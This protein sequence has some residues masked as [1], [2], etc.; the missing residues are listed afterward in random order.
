VR[1]Y[2]PPF[3]GIHHPSISPDGERILFTGV[4]RGKADLFEFDLAT[5]RITRHTNDPF[6]ESGAV[7]DST[8]RNIYFAS[9]ANRGERRRLD[10]TEREIYRLEPGRGII[11]ITDVKGRCENP[12]PAQNGALYLLCDHTG[13]ANV[14]RID[15]ADALRLSVGADGLTPITSSATGL[16]EPSLGLTDGSGE[17]LLFT[18]IEEGAR[19]IRML[20]S[21]PQKGVLTKSPLPPVSSSI[22]RPTGYE[23]P[24]AGERLVIDS[25]FPDAVSHYNPMLAPEFIFFM[26]SVSSEGYPAA[27]GFAQMSD[28]TGNHRLSVLLSGYQPQGG[29]QKVGNFSLQY[30]YR[31]YRNAFF[32]GAYKQSGTDPVLN[33]FDLSLN[34]LLYNPYFRLLQ[35]DTFGSYAGIEHPFHKYSAF[36]YVI[37]AGRDEKVFRANFPDE[38]R[39]E[40]IFHNYMAS[41]LSYRFDNS[42]YTPFGPLDGNSLTLSYSI[43]M[44]PTGSERSL[45]LST[46][47][48]KF[49]HIFGNYSS[50]ATRLFAGSSTGAD[51][52]LYPFRIGGYSTIRGYPL[53]AFEGTNAFFFNLE[54]RFTF[55]ER[56]FFAFPGRWTSG[57]IRGL[58]F[59]DGGGAFDDPKNFHPYYDNGQTRDLHMS[60]GTG[61][62]FMNFLWFI[63]PGSIMKIEWSSPYDLKRSLPITKWQGNFSIGFNF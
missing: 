16:L 47:D 50:I 28:D 52:D 57:T 34:D 48:Y 53:Q 21:D 26:A 8:G 18:E 4:L 39:Q 63:F 27:F 56:I 1:T 10:Q 12:M 17:A 5:R 40:D 41:T 31:K 62:H 37:S 43:P 59:V 13:V 19:E 36:Y 60:I 44:N 29:A 51:S 33:F 25:R 20:P 30:D 7:Y 35:Q 45:Y 24:S 32:T 46:I 54:Y 2:H 49:Y 14:Y 9:A 15:R 22:F 61:L 58:F 3:D 42:V 6:Y 38:R 55:I 23:F 11:R